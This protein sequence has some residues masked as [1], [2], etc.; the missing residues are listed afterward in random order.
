MS[1]QIDV[2][3]LSNALQ[4][5]VDLPSGKSQADIDYVVEWKV[6]TSSD[7]TWYRLYKSG[8]VEQGGVA[9]QYQITFSKPFRDTLYTITALPIVHSGD[10]GANDMQYLN[11]TTTSV[12]LRIR[13]SGSYA[14]ADNDERC[15][16]AEGMAAQ[17]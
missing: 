8:W 11:K 16:R 4:Q 2:N 13:W 5:K 10:S 3:Q 9:N 12:Q 1:D 14:P 17:S 6:P 7:P 15:W